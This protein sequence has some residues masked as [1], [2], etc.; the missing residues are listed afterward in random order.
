MN[1]LTKL[2]QS[3]K[4]LSILYIDSD[5][6]FHRS[7]NEYLKT[8]FKDVY[9]AHNGASAIR[10]FVYNKPDIILTDLC[11]SDKNSFE[12]I[13]DIKDQNDQVPII[14]LS[15]KNDEFELIE[16]LDFDI[17][18]LLEKPLDKNLLNN[19]LLLAVTNIEVKTKNL[20]DKQIIEN[21]IIQKTQIGAIN[22]YKGLVINQP[23]ELLSFQY[24]RLKIKISTVQF[25]AAIY[26]KQIIIVI[27]T[28]Q[29]LADVI[30]ANQKENQIT[31]TNFELLSSK[32]RDNRKKRI[33][34]DKSFK[35]K[36]QY[37]NIHVELQ[38]L[39]VS[40]DYISMKSDNDLLINVNDT[41]D[42]TIGFEIKAPSHLIK[43]KNFTKVFA[44]GKIIR[45]EKKN[46][47]Q[48]IIAELSVK[49]A[50]QNVFKKYLQERELEIIA[51]FKK[52]IQL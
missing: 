42:L 16:S 13:I 10:E 27:D 48:N 46:N 49:R 35:V 32:R 15:Q 21:A 51:E 45:V 2:K 7:V 28:N 47:K 5:L 1:I 30:D 39:D 11:F 36:I 19:A 33:L 6:N 25:I 8:L 14:I 31:V 38:T 12:V 40:Y 41:I 43:E 37:K 4:S 29:I 52:K 23:S 17:V 3:A 22:N 20:T 24:N 9:T 50:E 44:S 18:A 26:E 34:V